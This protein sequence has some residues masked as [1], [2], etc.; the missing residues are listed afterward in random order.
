MKFCYSDSRTVIKYNPETNK[1][2]KRK[3]KI[4]NVE[5]SNVIIDNYDLIGGQG[6]IKSP[7]LLMEKPEG[8]LIKLSD[9]RYAKV[10]SDKNYNHYARMKS[11][12]ER[13]ELISRELTNRTTDNPTPENIKAEHDWVDKEFVNKI[14]NAHP[15]RDLDWFKRHPVDLFNGLLNDEKAPSS[16]TKMMEARLAHGEDYKHNI[17]SSKERFHLVY[18]FSPDNIFSLRVAGKIERMIQELNKNSKI[19]ES[20]VFMIKNDDAYIDRWRTY[21][22]KYPPA[23]TFDIFKDKGQVEKI[24]NGD[25]F[26]DNEYKPAHL[27]KNVIDEKRIIAILVDKKRKKM[28]KIQFSSEKD[29]DPNTLI[30]IFKDFSGVGK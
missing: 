13:Y 26:S 16:L 28:K 8:K 22:K 15:K 7:L 5:D 4:E 14:N 30:S 20:T 10:I 2:E 17:L 3:E 21:Q 12:V 9:G 27:T 6:T 25:L 11:I 18:L 29:T 1:F 19:I 23:I 24:L